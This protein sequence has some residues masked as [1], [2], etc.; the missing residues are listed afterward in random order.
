[1]K[2]LSKIFIAIIAFLCISFSF[3]ACFPSCTAK[4]YYDY[5]VIWYS[6]DPYIVFAGDRHYGF[7][8]LDGKNYMLDIPHQPHGSKIYFY[9]EDKFNESGTIR[10]DYLIWEA[11]TKIKDGQLILTVIVDKV[12]DYAGKTVI[13]DQK[14]IED[15]SY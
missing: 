8:E 12:S 10:S 15:G 2:K 4:Y 11:D 13:L 7:M 6:E 5:H 14:P 9:D 3:S 1:M